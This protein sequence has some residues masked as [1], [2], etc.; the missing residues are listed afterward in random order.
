[1]KEMGVLKLEPH[2]F[3]QIHTM[4]HIFWILAC[5]FKLAKQYILIKAVNM[6]IERF[7]KMAFPDE[8]INKEELK[9]FNGKNN[10]FKIWAIIF[11]ISL[12][13]FTFLFTWV[14]IENVEKK[15]LNSDLSRLLL[16]IVQTMIDFLLPLHYLGIRKM[17]Q[18]N[19]GIVGAFSAATSLF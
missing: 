2:W 12:I 19:L 7:K 6:K 11:V 8:K 4:K 10:F 3:K 15:S 16:S 14:N 17:S 13:V 9:F 1:M 18:K 5:L